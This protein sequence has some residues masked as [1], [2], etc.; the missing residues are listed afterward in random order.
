MG[1]IP[2]E[3]RYESTGGDTVCGFYLIGLPNQ[4]VEIEFVDFDISCKDGGLLAVRINYVHY[5]CDSISFTANPLI[6]FIETN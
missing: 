1:S 5:R 6:Y 3:Y 4:L 2:G